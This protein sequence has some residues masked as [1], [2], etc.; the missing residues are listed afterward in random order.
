[1]AW[2]VCYFVLDI[3]LSI[4]FSLISVL[5]VIPPQF[6]I[7]WKEKNT[8]QSLQSFIELYL[9]KSIMGA[10]INFNI[11]S[12]CW[13]LV[14]VL[15]YVNELYKW[16]WPQWFCGRWSWN[17]RIYFE[18]KKNICWSSHWKIMNSNSNVASIDCWLSLS[19][20]DV[21]FYN[22][23]CLLWYCPDRGF[24]LEPGAWF[25]LIGWM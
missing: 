25:C 18:K 24:I 9:G 16:Q 4:Y 22:A 12:M 7:T 2:M 13:V 14:H 20:G 8:M 3:N 11:K 17:Q 15:V 5:G 23:K 1:M 19:M 6:I 10:K 21:E